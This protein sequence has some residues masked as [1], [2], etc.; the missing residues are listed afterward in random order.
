MVIED[1]VDMEQAGSTARQGGS[2]PRG[3]CLGT[4]G[5]FLGK[6]GDER[7]TTKR[8]IPSKIKTHTHREREREREKVAKT[9]RTRRFNQSSQ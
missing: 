1:S 8:N 4:K 5:M 2:S 3:T 9:G 6:W 7:A